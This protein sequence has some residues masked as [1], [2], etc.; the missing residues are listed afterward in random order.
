MLIENQFVEV[1]WVKNNQQ[2]YQ[3]KGYIFTKIGDTF[4]VDANDLSPGSHAKVKVLCDYCNE[5]ITVYWKDYYKYKQKNTKYACA[6]CRQKK[7]S[8]NNLIER[9]RHLYDGMLETCKNRGLILLTKIEEIVN[10]ESRVSFLCP[11]HGIHETKAYTLYLGF[12]C[13]QC[14]YDGIRLS[15]DEV[16]KRINSY[17][18]ELL[19][20]E[21][22]INT[23]TKNL[24]IT[25]RQC[26]NPF[27]TS[28]NSFSCC[29]GGQYCPEC[30]KYESLGEKAVRL[31]LENNNIAFIQQYSFVDCRDKHVLP[32]DF[33]LIDYNMIIEYDGKQHYIPSLWGNSKNKSD[34]YKN[35]EYIQNHDK[36]KNDYCK[37]NN[38]TL[39]RIP[40]WDFNRIND[41]LTE[42]I[43]IFT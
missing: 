12:G 25:C 4:L 21:D 38:V 3:D 31:F 41:I 28:Y 37:K 16:E 18:A 1:K 42:Y 6:K 14:Q 24:K 11:L 17:G 30:T 39:V 2:W 33:Y 23:T 5:I 36:I 34:G 8:E 43:K 22:Y 15:K 27:I 9:Q 35:L 40:Y 19:N 13:P 32:F 20:K 10:S 7:T 29:N 26:G